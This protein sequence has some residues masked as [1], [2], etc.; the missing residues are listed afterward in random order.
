MLNPITRYL[1]QLEGFLYGNVPN[2]IARSLCAESN[3]HLH[4]LA[5]EFKTQGLTDQEAEQAAVDRFGSAGKLAMRIIIEKGEEGPAPIINW[6]KI[7]AFAVGAI[8]LAW[9]GIGNHSILNGEPRYYLLL[10]ICAIAFLL[11][12]AKSRKAHVAPLLAMAV[13]ASVLVGGGVF[14]STQQ[15]LRRTGYA[16][17]QLA[18]LNRR[19]DQLS[20]ATQVSVL[21]LFRASDQ[22]GLG[23]REAIRELKSRYEDSIFAPGS[24]ITSQ[25][26]SLAVAG[27]FSSTSSNGTQTLFYGPAPVATF[28]K[29]FDTGN[30]DP[31]T[32]VVASGPAF[33]FPLGK[34][35]TYLRAQA[36]WREKLQGYYNVLSPSLVIPEPVFVQSLDP[37][38]MGLGIFL[39]TLFTLLPF[40]GFDAWHGLVFAPSE[41]QRRAIRKMIA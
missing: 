31:T 4:D 5:D 25:N 29:E 20:G 12:S 2:E 38:K 33:A 10:T 35:T 17:S 24:M 21:S 18:H 11:A 26:A 23:D 8:V 41:A 7:S 15:Y 39:F 3:A 28:R 30:I 16:S 13:V 22:F 36:L 32:E 6:A 27:P 9:F 40:V 19:W 1:G 14:L 34:L 37:S